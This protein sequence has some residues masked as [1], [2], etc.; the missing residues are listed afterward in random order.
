MC[1]DLYV[2]ILLVKQARHAVR[3]GTWLCEYEGGD[4]TTINVSRWNF[5]KTDIVING[6]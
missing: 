4:A 6:H 2:P 1:A 3:V 5:V